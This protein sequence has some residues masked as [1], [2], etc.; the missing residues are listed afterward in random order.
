MSP[1]EGVVAFVD[2]RTANAAMCSGLSAKLEQ[3]GAQVTPTLGQAVTH[4]VC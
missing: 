4:L 2:V 3:M 1:S